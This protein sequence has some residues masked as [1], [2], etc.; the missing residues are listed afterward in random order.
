MNETSDIS[1]QSKQDLIITC[2]KLNID[3]YS[4]KTKTQLISMIEKKLNKT[5]NNK[6]IYEKPIIKWVGGKTQII[7][8]IIEKFPTEIIN[9]HE[10]FLGGG[11]VLLALLQNIEQGIIK[12]NGSINAYDIN[13]TL[14]NLYKNIQSNYVDVLLEINKIIFVYNSINDTSVNRKPE[15]IL[16]AKTS[17][18]SY[19]YWIRKQYNMLTQQE[20]NTSL[21]SAYFIFLNK[22][23]FRG[24][25]REGPNG[26]NVPF[27]HYKNPEI[28]NE[29]HIEKISKMIKDVRFYC[30]CFE[31]SFS[32]IDE[33]DF[34]YL[35]PPYAPE[36]INSF[37]GYTELGFNIKQHELL[38]SICKKFKF[39]MSNSDVEL[40]K[41]NFNNNDYII[42][43]ILCK[44][45]INSKKPDSKTNELLIKSY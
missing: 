24:V 2:K 34:V 23:C 26:F 19:F 12:I 9:Y 35:D 30:L 21:G 6:I 1:K 40:V 43:I 33:N 3:K 15:N 8:K 20:K 17:Q 10:L 7:D 22:T 14:I 29:T 38:F 41:N 45:A 13:E 27:G 16:Q 39:L 11:S 44:R 31:E 4:N 28:I 18:E 32:K 5:D 36:N 37:V 25:Y 42:D